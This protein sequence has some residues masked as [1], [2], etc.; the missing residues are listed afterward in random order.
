MSVFPILSFILGIFLTF[1][2]FFTKNNLGK[3]NY[4]RYFLGAVTFIYSLLSLDT[5][6][7][8]NK[9]KLPVYVW[10]FSFLLFSL[11]GFLFYAFT[12]NLA[13]KHSDDKKWILFFSL[14]SVLKIVFFIYASSYIDKTAPL[15]DSKY[16]KFFE[17]EF[18][19]SS[20]INLYFFY[21]SAQ[22]FKRK[23][24]V[25]DLEDKNHVY[26]HWINLLLKANVLLVFAILLEAIFAF[27]DASLFPILFKI[28]PIFYTIFFFVLVYSLMYFP[29]FALTGDHEDVDT[30]PK[31]KN[32]KLHN[33]SELFDRIDSLVTSEKLY[34]S[35]KLK[36]NV[37]AERLKCPV[38]Y[39]SQAI[40]ENK[41]MS[42]S[43]YIN[44]FRIEEAKKKLLQENP[45]TIFAIAIDVG[46]NSKAAFYNAFKKLT[47]TTPTQ[48][49]KENLAKAEVF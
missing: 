22:F 2:I 11:V 48:Y 26:F 15:S 7:T 3:K 18:I 5:F 16:L 46:F 43:D 20:M 40:N 47:N 24:A 6:T 31:Y 34:L 35:Y 21:K 4:V 25:I 19:L 44:S 1:F 30:I 37:I 38:P 9:F 28:E 41:K 36:L 8:A 33:S 17:I 45:D 49:R 29:V 13:Q 39:V 27:F 23:N 12:K 32:S 14:F 42:F 10:F